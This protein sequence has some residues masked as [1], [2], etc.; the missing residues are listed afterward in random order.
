MKRD[1]QWS[2]FF[3]CVGVAVL[4]LLVS[5]SSAAAQAND[6]TNGQNNNGRGDDDDRGGFAVP[7]GPGTNTGNC[8]AP[9][10]ATDRV[11]LPKVYCPYPPGLIPSELTSE[12]ERVRREIRGIEEEAMAQAAAL[13][14]LVPTSPSQ[15]LAGNGMRAVQVLGKLINYD[16]NL[17]VFKNVA[18]AFCHMPYAGFSGPI[19]SLNETTVAYPGSFQFR[20][21]KRKPQSYDYSPYYPVLHFNIQ[22]HN[23]YGGNFWDLR[24]TGYKIQ[25]PDSEQAQ[26]PPLD[27]QE[28]GNPDFGCVV[29][30]LSQAKYRPLFEGIWGK[31][32]FDIDF[33]HDAE[34]ICR[35][36]AGAFG[37]N[38]TP[39]RLSPTSR[40][41]A[42]AT[43]DAFAHS[44]TAFENGPEVSPFSSKFD[45]FLAG[46]A[47]LSTDE[48]A[49]YNL[50]RGKGNCNSCHLDGRSTAPST[51]E[52]PN[53]VD[54]GAAADVEPLFTDTTSS[55]LGLPKPFPFDPIYYENK[56]DSFGFIPN[57]AGADFKDLGVGL[58]L[59]SQSGVNPDSNWTGFAPAFD[60]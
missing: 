25:S 52:A 13:G 45:A 32:S 3:L 24:A 31:Q 21:G 7:Q 51:L 53:G 1:S 4:A 2:V 5:V 29:F 59:R 50:F 17:S 8:P 55:N 60:G 57:P 26:G 10:P 35:T 11:I 37:S 23:F 46:K 6:G 12:S 54:T 34:K 27:T 48:M 44:I 9:P 14:P 28:M 30:R 22:Q 40:G 42:S 16:E 41:T 19:P 58:F 15:T 38:P 43:F 18:C 49:G 36:P 33:P 56:P 39:L 20:F 47:T